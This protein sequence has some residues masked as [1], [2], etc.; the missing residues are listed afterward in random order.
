MNNPIYDIYEHIYDNY[1]HNRDSHPEI[2]VS[3]YTCAYGNVEELEARYQ[4]ANHKGEW[5]IYQGNIFCQGG[6]C[7]NCEIGRGE[8]YGII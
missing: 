6:Y 2:P 3:F 4:M 1:E 7:N 5:C 8:N